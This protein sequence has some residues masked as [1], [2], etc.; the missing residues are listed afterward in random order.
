MSLE[1]FEFGIIASAADSVRYFGF[2]NS[3]IALAID[4][5][6][7]ESSTRSLA[8][9][10]RG[11]S[12]LFEGVDSRR[13]EILRFLVKHRSVDLHELDSERF[14]REVNPDGVFFVRL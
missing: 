8:L 1:S 5:P 2:N 9:D 10:A 3:R 7:G 6:Y 11:E 12:V 4:A 14:E 13:D